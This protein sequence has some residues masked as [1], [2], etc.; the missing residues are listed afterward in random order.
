MDAQHVIRAA[1]TRANLGLR[2]LARR[3]GTSHATLSAYEAGT[4]IPR[5]DTVVHI[6]RAAGF[7]LDAV[8]APRPDATVEERER[9][10]RQLEEVLV[11]ASQFPSRHS[12]QLRA[13][14]FRRA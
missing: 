9:K 12:V 2:E 6:V 1:R 13:P 7:E 14:R 3:A 10:G 11:L 5:V 4:K 8:L